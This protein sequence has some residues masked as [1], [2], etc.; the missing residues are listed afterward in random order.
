MSELHHFKINTWYILRHEYYT[1]LSGRKHYNQHT[2][3]CFVV[4]VLQHFPLGG[5]DEV[6]NSTLQ[7]FAKVIDEASTCIYFIYFTT[8]CHAFTLTC[9]TVV[10]RLEVQKFH[11]MMWNCC[12]S[13]S[14]GLHNL[15]VK[16][17]FSKVST[18]C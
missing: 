12:C 18:H 15:Q 7:Q 3:F 4:F 1:C 2:S 9:Y 5:D 14:L 6:M 17:R 8:F 11:L 13:I 10:F 16:N